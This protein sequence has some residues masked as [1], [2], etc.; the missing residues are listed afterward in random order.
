MTYPTMT[1]VSN[2]ALR[3]R[4]Q[5]ARQRETDP[6]YLAKNAAY[7][8]AYRERKRAEILNPL[9][10]EPEEQQVGGARM[11][12]MT[13][14]QL[15]STLYDYSQANDRGDHL[16]KEKT[17]L[18]YAKRLLYMTRVLSGDSSATLI[19]MELFRDVDRVWAAV[20]NG[21]SASGRTKGQPWSL[22]SKIV[23]MSAITG[24]M[25]RI[26][27]FEKQ[28]AQYGK[29]FATL[30]K[31]YD[32][33][34]KGNTMSPAEESKFI[35]WSALQCIYR[36][37]ISNLNTTAIPM[38]D[39]ALVSLYVGIPPRRAADYQLMY[40]ADGDT[41]MQPDRNYLMLDRGK[42]SALI[43]NVYKTSDRYGTYTI[44]EIPDDVVRVLT[45]YLRV[46]GLSSGSLLFPTRGNKQYSSGAFSTLIGT[47]FR[48]LT[49]RR[50]TVNILRHAAITH[51]LRKK[52][53]VASREA[54]A[55]QMGHSIA[56]Q[57]LYDRITAPPDSDDDTLHAPAL[58]QKRPAPQAPKPTRA[59]PT[60]SKTQKRR[61]ARKIAK[62][63]AARN[64]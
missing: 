42:V 23:Y 9:I 31:K 60:L 2:V 62:M 4:A 16:I 18:D 24:T 7:A 19:D 20:R 30:H 27:G 47:T 12:P 3:K 55:L 10:V 50:A 48:N 58:P 43:F 32:S 36:A 15:A 39:L 13:I 29:L 21:T 17:A 51:F 53:T 8:K 41:A 26:P 52:R 37:E 11:T 6:D 63:R 59:A 34:R 54:Y 40:I 56:M 38:R 64:Q 57:A 5:R 61:A 22:A 1:T 28:Y 45:E 14:K 33:E 49:G 46:S 44:D 25:R 35:T